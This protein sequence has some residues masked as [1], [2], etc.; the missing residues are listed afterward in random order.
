MYYGGSPGTAGLPIPGDYDGNGT[1]QEADF[2]QWRAVFGTTVQIPGSGADGNVN[3]KVDAADYTVWR[4]NVGHTVPPLGW[5]HGWRGRR[6]AALNE[7]AAPAQSTAPVQSTASADSAMSIDL[8]VLELELPNRM[9]PPESPA[10]ATVRQTASRTT[11]DDGALLLLAQSRAESPAADD[12]SVDR[13][14]VESIE[15]R[16]EEQ[17]DDLFAR[18][19]DAGELTTDFD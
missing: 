11:L 3:G 15:I 19:G 2:Q 1:V 9:P 14:S 12:A 18:L 5:R 16:L 10:A 4:D 8:A 6:G 13:A 17:V 7:S